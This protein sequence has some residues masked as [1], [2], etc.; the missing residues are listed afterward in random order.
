MRY[1]EEVRVFFLEY[2]PLGLSNGCA[3]RLDIVNATIFPVLQSRSTI[4]AWK[5]YLTRENFGLF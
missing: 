3:I 2:T 1:G 4:Q 5:I